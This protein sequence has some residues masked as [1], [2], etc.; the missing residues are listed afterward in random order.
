[1]LKSKASGDSSSSVASANKKIV[2]PAVPEHPSY[3]E[4][5]IAAVAAL[6]TRKGSSCQAIVKY[7]KA[8]YP[9][10]VGCD[11]FLK[12][13][14]VGA[15]KAG[16]LLRVSGRGAS[17]SFKVAKPEKKPTVKT[18]NT[19]TVKKV[20]KTTKKAVSPKK[21]IA[22]KPVKKALKKVVKKSSPTKKKTLKKVVKKPV[23][24]KVTT[25]KAKKPAAKK[26]PKKSTTKKV[27]AKK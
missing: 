21:K 7:V 16:A 2:K 3:K 5:A 11:M 14:V 13:G 4:M 8:N 20:V 27:A 26:T 19:S 17:G 24:K 22:K 23:T 10:K 15:V 12:K 25:I 6:K 1:M 9:V 18:A